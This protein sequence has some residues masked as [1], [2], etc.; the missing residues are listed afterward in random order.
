MSPT[1]LSDLITRLVQGGDD[2]I[3]TEFH[4][5]FADARVGVTIDQPPDVPNGTTI[6]GGGL[7]MPKFRTPD[8][9]AVVRACADPEIFVERYDPTVNARTSGRAVLE[10]VLQ[11]DPDVV[12]VLVASAASEHS[13]L[14]KRDRIP[15]ILAG[16]TTMA[17]KPWWKFW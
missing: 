10:M 14:I 8:G 17:N 5:A 13:V 11:L 12:G 7:Q 4:A 15:S 6:D 1:P 16:E 2:S 9:R 3:A